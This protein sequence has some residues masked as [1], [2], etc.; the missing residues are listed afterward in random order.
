MD[1]TTEEIKQPEPELIRVRSVTD[2]RQLSGSIINCYK[3]NQAKIDA[4]DSHI[5]EI[6]IILR[7]IGAGALNQAV[8]GATTSNKYFGQLG[9]QVILVP[10]FFSIDADT[11]A[12]ELRVEIRKINR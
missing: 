6:P 10:S 9:Q 8:K 1:A 2:V 4:V 7:T 11:T 12:L 3:K 5:K